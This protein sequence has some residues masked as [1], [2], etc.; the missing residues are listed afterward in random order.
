M[1]ALKKA[2]D[3]AKKLEEAWKLE[4]EKKKK[5]EEERKAK[6]EEDRKKKEEEE[7]AALEKVDGEEPEE[8]EEEEKDNENEMKEGE[9]E[10]EEELFKGIKIPTD[11]KEKKVFINDLQKYNSLF[12]FLYNL[13]TYIYKA[14]PRQYENRPQLTTALKVLFGWDENGMTF[15]ERIKSKFKSEIDPDEGKKLEVLKESNRH[16]RGLL[17]NAS[18]ALEDYIT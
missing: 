16:Q 4:E 8:E 3:D 9:Q 12:K 15:T 1:D 10:G 2:E 14:G 7:A 17:K 18:E 13:N 6:E 11:P 5:E